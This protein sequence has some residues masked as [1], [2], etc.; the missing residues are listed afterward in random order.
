M[1]DNRFSLDDILNEYPRKEGNE[2]KNSVSSE[3][4]EI[5]AKSDIPERKWERDLK[6]LSP[7]VSATERQL[8]K[9]ILPDMSASR[10]ES[11]NPLP[12]PDS[13]ETDQEEIYE[14]EKL[15]AKELR[16]Q[17]K[18]RKQ[19]EKE[20][21]RME[22]QYTGELPVASPESEHS[23]ADLE[24]TIYFP[25]T[26]SSEGKQGIT[27]SS[28][29]E[30]P[31]HRRYRDRLRE[32]QAIEEA[33]EHISYEGK[34]VRP[35]PSNR[36]S[37]NTEIIDSLMRIKRDRVARTS[38]IPPVARKSFSDIEAHLEGKIL[39]NTAQLPTD[40]TMSEIEK[41]KDLQERRKK[42]IDEF[43][44]TGED[45]VSEEPEEETVA[46]RE[47]EDFESFEDAP[48]IQSDLLQLK[49]SLL[50]RLIFLTITFCA[51]LY[52]SASGDYGAPIPDLLSRE[53]NPT[54]FLFTLTILGLLSAFVSYTVITCGLSKMFTLQGDCDSM[55]ALAIVSSLLSSMACLG[56]PT[57]IQRGICNLYI[58]VAIGS[59]LFNTVGKLLIVGRTSRNFQ[60]V[61][62]DHERYAMFTVDNDERA[63][64]FTR[65]ALTDFPILASMR[66]TEFLSDF[67]K[68]SYSSDTSDRFCRIAAP[69][70]CGIGLLAG[71]LSILLSTGISMTDAVLTGLSIFAG[72][73]GMSSCFAIMLVINLPLHRA[74]KHNREQSAAMLSWQSAEEFADTNSVLLD[75]AQLF[76]QGM[77]NL[78][79][80][81]FFSDTKIDEAIVEAASLTNQ[82]GSILKYMFYDIIVGKTEMLNPVES[83]I[84]EDSLGLCGWIENKRILLGGRELMKNHSIEGVPT[85]QKEREYTEGGKSAIYLSISGELS[86]MFVVDVKPSLE[87]QKWL[88]VLEKNNISIILRSV[89]SLISINRLSEMFDI[90]ANMFRFLPFRLH[91]DF[92]NETNYKPRQSATMAC[93]GRFGA[94]ASLLISARRLRHVANIGLT[95]QAAAAFLG[96][97]LSVVLVCM[98]SFDQITALV[99]VVYNMAFVL[100]TVLIQ[101]FRKI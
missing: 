68:I 50:I 75:M 83:Y 21:R 89:D 62:G 96:V 11:E 42:K 86:A 16:A 19:R 65:G 14:R 9:H 69:V 27:L 18:R 22:K 36:I 46:P 30:P 51:S 61:A 3:N 43:I 80:I 99:A 15:S 40:E 45:E 74:A 85:E 71:G 98:S 95:L 26:A 23:T 41:L 66:K 25:K 92:D 17:A 7:S 88:G 33:A 1:S 70:I 13:V 63:S 32:R 91:P 6:A 73:V 29:Q 54:V 28:P 48:A 81:K 44:L 67:L 82:A 31:P 76:P 53:R 8:R 94:F 39:P 84:Y 4:G 55:S 57:L 72:T 47:I 78:A 93:S 90:S 35:I 12:L 101:A 58:P 24:P 34:N 38:L 52:L 60:F 59:L 56:N 79:N 87:V 37:G 49:G 20:C 2:E 97:L 100:L 5:S 64:Q 10:M 77:V